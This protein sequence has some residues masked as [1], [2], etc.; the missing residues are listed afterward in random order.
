MYIPVY[1][2][3]YFLISNNYE[4]IYIRLKT[5]TKLLHHFKQMYQSSAKHLFPY[6]SNRKRKCS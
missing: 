4:T 2:S 5:Y 1:V 3:T 6:Y